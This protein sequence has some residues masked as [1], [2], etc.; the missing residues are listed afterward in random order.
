MI[1]I[2]CKEEV[3]GTD[4]K[5]MLGIDKPYINLWLHKA[6]YRSIIDDLDSFFTQQTIEFMYN[7]YI[8]N[9]DKNGK[10]TRKNSRK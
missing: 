6:C 5:T 10:N 9:K 8:L 2:V 1:C 4:D 3:L 7:T